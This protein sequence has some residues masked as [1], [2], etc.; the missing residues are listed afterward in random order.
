MWIP[1][2]YKATAVDTYGNRVVYLRT[3][4]SLMVRMIM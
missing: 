4:L 3:T 2:A 1:P